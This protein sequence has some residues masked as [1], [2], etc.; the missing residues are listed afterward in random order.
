MA[1]RKISE[2]PEIDY[3]LVEDVDL[4]TLVHV[5]EVDPTLR[6]KR[7]TFSGLKG[8]LDQRYL[9]AAGVPASA[10]ASGT[11]GEIAWDS[12]HLYICTSANTW[13]RTTIS[14]W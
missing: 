9:P 12:T 7:F 2:L 6:N 4:I 5:F 14:S 8:Y 1:N 13:K 10:T 3:S 11:A